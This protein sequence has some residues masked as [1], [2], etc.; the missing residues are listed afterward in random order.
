MNQ[1]ELKLGTTKCVEFIDEKTLKITSKAEKSPYT[2][3]FDRV[4]DESS[5][6]KDVFEFAAKPIINS[7][8]FYLNL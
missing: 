6:Q 1:K 2:F 3:S 8:L 7:K 5:L 4:F